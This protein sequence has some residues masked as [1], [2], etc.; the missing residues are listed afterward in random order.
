MKKVFYIAAAALAFMSCG[1][2]DNVEGIVVPNEKQIEWANDEI[3]VMYAYDMQVYNPDYE[4][5]H[6]G[7]HPDASTYNPTDL[8]TDQWLEAASKIGAKY[9]VLVAKHCCGFSLWPTEAHDYS[10][11]NSP[12]KNGKGDIVKDFVESCKKYGIKPGIYA[13]TSANGYYYVNN[14]GLVQENSPYTQEEYNKVV[15]KQLTELWSNYG[16]LFE[17]WFDG[18]VLAME[19][20]GVNVISLME[21]LQPETIAFQ[22][23][24]GH[25]NCLRWVGNERGEA[26]YPCWATCSGGTVDDG[27]TEYTGK[28]GDPFGSKWI[29]GESDFTLRHNDTRQGGWMWSEGEDDKLFSVDELMNKYETSVGRNTNMLLGLVIDPSGR[30]PE[31][32][33]ARLE[34]FGK[35]LKEKYGNPVKS[36]SG[37]GTEFVLKFSKPENINRVVIQEDIAFGER[38]L[39]FTVEGQTEDGSWIAIAIGSNIGNKHIEVFDQ[40]KVSKIKLT[41]SN[42]KAK[43]IIKNF[44][45]FAP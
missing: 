45:A 29:P 31:G 18:G 2:N 12:W 11:K 16:D 24:E 30:V 33:V 7:T 9:A 23:P 41:V 6:W 1:N 21:K 8:D 44:A 3:G 42:C 14:P 34:E 35:S 17:I 20:G 22:G 26:P 32:D 39:D 36:V 19:N 40:V 28:N 10:I 38:V 13:S 15:E 25:K 4:W 43:P 5:R 37:K 27:M